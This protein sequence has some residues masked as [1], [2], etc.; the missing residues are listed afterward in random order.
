MSGIQVKRSIIQD[1]TWMLNCKYY[2]QGIVA[3]LYFLYLV[4]TDGLYFTSN[5]LQSLFI[6]FVQWKYIVLNMWYIKSLAPWSEGPA[7]GS[8]HRTNITSILV[9]PGLSI[10][11]QILGHFTKEFI[12]QIPVP[13]SCTIS[14]TNIS[15]TCFM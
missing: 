12:A 2:S 10:K 11:L 1:R 5:T 3:F 7:W 14:H 4:A 15:I 6:I 9:R 13:I 8:V